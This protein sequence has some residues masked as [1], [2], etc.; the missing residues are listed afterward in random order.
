MV[1]NLSKGWAREGNIFGAHDFLPVKKLIYL[2]AGSFFRSPERNN[3]EPLRE[4][5]NKAEA[6]NSER[7][8]VGF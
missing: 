7:G 1:L 6:G 8:G 3:P 2:P 4:E 5:P